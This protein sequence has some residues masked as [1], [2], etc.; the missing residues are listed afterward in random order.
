MVKLTQLRDHVVSR[1]V[2]A[3]HQFPC[4]GGHMNS[5]AQMNVRSRHV[6]GTTLEYDNAIRQFSCDSIDQT[7][8]ESAVL[9]VFYPEC[10]KKTKW[11]IPFETI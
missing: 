1:M 4:A 7:G 11:W 9:F 5:C 6:D 8:V 2:I 3:M 10:S